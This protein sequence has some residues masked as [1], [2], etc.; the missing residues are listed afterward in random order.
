[1]LVDFNDLLVVIFNTPLSLII[2]TTRKC[3]PVKWNN[4]NGT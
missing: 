4:Y 2:T 3:E 1:M